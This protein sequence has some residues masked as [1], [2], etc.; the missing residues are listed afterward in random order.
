MSDYK[1]TTKSGSWVKS[2]WLDEDA[3]AYAETCVNT[4]NEI[5]VERVSIGKW[6]PIK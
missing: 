5:S 1:F 4:L 2:F 6:I 3:L